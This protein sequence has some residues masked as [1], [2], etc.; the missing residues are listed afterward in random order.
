[1]V[2]NG[3]NLSRSHYGNSDCLLSVKRLSK[4]LKKTGNV[5]IQ[6]V[7]AST[8]AV[9]YGKAIMHSGLKKTPVKIQICKLLVRRTVICWEALCRWVAVFWAKQQID[10]GRWF[11][12]G[13][14]HG[15]FTPGGPDGGAG[16]CPSR[17]LST[18][19]CCVCT[20]LSLYFCWPW[21]L[22]RSGLCEY[23]KK[24]KE[25]NLM[26]HAKENGEAKTK[27]WKRKTLKRK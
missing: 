19:H 12:G 14:S 8:C 26:S 15:R 22:N 13:L 24:R 9:L 5:T 4:T 3:T 21:T 7:S 6:W 11:Y 10:S 1:M 2:H 18:F 25:E 20:V 17:C 27:P 16:I 23:S